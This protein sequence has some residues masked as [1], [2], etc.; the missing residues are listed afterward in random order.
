MLSYRHR[1]H[2][3]NF[4]DVF[5]HAALARLLALLTRKDAPL[6]Y[7]D[8]HAGLGV[9]DLSHPWS[10]KNAEHAKGIAR[11]WDRTDAPEALGRVIW[12]GST[13]TWR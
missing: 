9:Y 6:A 3:G 10:R 8:T 1:F 11:V 2:A 4:A 5:K 13:R 12:S 7:V